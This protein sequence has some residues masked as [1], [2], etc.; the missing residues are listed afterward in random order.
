MFRR[1]SSTAAVR[2]AVGSTPSPASSINAAFSKSNLQE[3]VAKLQASRVGPPKPKKQEPTHRHSSVL[4]PLCTSQGNK[5]S[6]LFNLRSTRL[7]RHK[8]Y[9]CFPGGIQHDEDA[10][11]LDTALREAE[12]EL[13]LARSKIE[14]VGTFPPFYN[15]K[16]R[17]TMTVAVGMLGD[18]QDLDLERDLN[19]NDNEVQLAFTGTLEELC[20]PRNLR[21]T[22]FRRADADYAMPVFLVGQFKVW[23]LTAMILNH[24]L[25]AL[26]PGTYVHDVKCVL[27]NKSLYM[28]PSNHMKA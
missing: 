1:L 17:M 6:L 19:V 24:F 2:A 12:E 10:S 21:Y 18:G 27:L 22:Q 11:P 16:D 23:G 28:K 13:G 4:I 3:C 20:D 7:P 14:V 5:P 15:K 8:G 25:K 9:V 26:L